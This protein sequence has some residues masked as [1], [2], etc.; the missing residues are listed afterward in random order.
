MTPRFKW[1]GLRRDESGVALT[2]FCIVIPVILI[3]FMSMLQY[4]I[5]LQTAQLGDYAAYTAARSYSVRAKAD[6]QPDG[7]S[8]VDAARRSAA[9]A[10]GPAARLA[11]FGSG[12]AGSWLNGIEGLMG[13]SSLSS[14]VGGCAIADALLNL[15]GVFPQPQVVA[16]G[17]HFQ[18]VVAINYPQ[19]INVP[20]LASLWNMLG[21]NGPQPSLLNSPSQYMETLEG[22]AETGQSAS[23]MAVSLAKTGNAAIY[24]LEWTTGMP[25][26]NIACNAQ[27]GC[28]EW[29]GTLKQSVDSPPAYKQ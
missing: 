11:N 3:L 22:E 7:V 26:V 1:K 20:G 15:S 19:Q 10:L 23:S 6:N 13:G 18:A 27:T 5:I 21:E 2:E 9:M 8:A 28:E 17:S 25:Y 29:S 16:V 4:L 24:G 14:Y 12:V